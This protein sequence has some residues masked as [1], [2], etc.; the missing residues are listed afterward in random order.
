MN[1]VKGVYR[2]IPQSDHFRCHGA[3]RNA[4]FLRKTKVSYNINSQYNIISQL[5]RIPKEGKKCFIKP[6]LQYLFMIKIAKYA[7]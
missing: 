2:N 5:K 3:Q 4:V 1:E 7:Q 6:F